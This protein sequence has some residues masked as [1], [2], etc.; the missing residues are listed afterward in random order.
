VGRWILADTVPAKHC[1]VKGPAADLKLRRRLPGP[2]LSVPE[3]GTEAGI[4]FWGETG[5][6][7]D[8]YAMRRR[9]SWRYDG[10]RD[11]KSRKYGGRRAL[12]EAVRIKK[13]A[14]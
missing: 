4:D 11:V 2:S 13:I 10:V 3:S 12:A 6:L 1:E 5:W 9:D 7:A 14:V 8:E